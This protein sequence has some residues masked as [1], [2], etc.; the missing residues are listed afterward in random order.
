MPTTAFELDLAG[1][2]VTPS[3]SRRET[4]GGGDRAQNDGFDAVFARTSSARG[5]SGPID[6]ER[7][8]VGVDGTTRS[9]GARE[10]AELVSAEVRA[11]VDDDAETSIGERAEVGGEATSDGIEPRPR[12]DREPVERDPQSSR[13]DGS[14]APPRLDEVDADSEIDEEDAAVRVR[15]A[16]SQPVQWVGGVSDPRV[17]AGGD[18]DSQERGEG[19]VSK[20]GARSDRTNASVIE[21]AASGLANGRG[22]VRVGSGLP[23]EG[24]VPANGTG[25]ASFQPGAEGVSGQVGLGATQVTTSEASVLAATSAPESASG[26]DSVEQASSPASARAPGSAPQAVQGTQPISGDALAPAGVTDDVVDEPSAGAERVV[27]DGKTHREAAGATIAP[28]R[29]APK[30]SSKD[31]A[32]ASDRVQAQSSAAGSGA[33]ASGGDPGAGNASKDGGEHSRRGP[34][35]GDPAAKTSAESSAAAS[36]SGAERGRAAESPAPTAGQ[37]SSPTI[38]GTPTPASNAIP[39][40]AGTER[41]D[42][43]PKLATTNSGEAETDARVAAAARRGIAA[44]LNQRGGPVTIKLHPETLGQISVRIETVEGRSAIELEATTKA[45]ER[46]LRAELSSLRAQLESKGVRVERL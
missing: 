9:E 22:V 1:A 45:A 16:L 46:A 38:A 17:S 39:S 37:S 8:S 14:E 10:R 28:D 18:A 42:A 30:E 12:D 26:N 33:G 25:A 41:I 5:D 32:R 6:R 44:A 19:A 11:P 4:A 15:D 29:E 24:G 43:A 36:T 20:P 27:V 7:P 21:D 34:S 35:G 3:R 23:E 40:L 13:S 2:S 31:D